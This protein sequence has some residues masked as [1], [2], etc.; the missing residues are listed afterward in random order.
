ME[1]FVIDIEWSDDPRWHEGLPP[2]ATIIDV[3]DESEI[4]GILGSEYNCKVDTFDVRRKVT[5]ED[6]HVAQNLLANR[7]KE[8]ILL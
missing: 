8:R 3:Q 4:K 6:L 7:L 1:I 2:T 5:E